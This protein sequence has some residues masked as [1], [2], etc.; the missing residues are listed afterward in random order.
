MNNIPS[1]ERGYLPP[2]GC[3]DLIDVLKLNKAKSIHA[4]KKPR[5]NG[6][7]K[8]P[9]VRVI[10]F[11]TTQLGILPIGAALNLAKEHVSSPQRKSLIARPSKLRSV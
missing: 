7:I 9:Q 3:K 8:A 5:V 2:K 1:K 4:E 6:Q 11:P 10:E